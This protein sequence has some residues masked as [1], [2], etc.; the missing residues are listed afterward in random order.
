[1]RGDEPWTHTV[2]DETTTAARA[3]GE[4]FTAHALEVFDRLGADPALDGARRVLEW[5]TTKHITRFTKRDA[6][7][8]LRVSVGWS[9]T[10]E[11]VDALLEA[12]PRVVS[13]LRRLGAG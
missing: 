11:D 3:L 13:D 9:S 12:L 2:S 5:I 8:S 4:Y 1:M 10:D 7:R 6:H